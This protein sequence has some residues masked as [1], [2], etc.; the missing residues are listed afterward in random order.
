MVWC[1]VVWCGVVWCGVVCITDSVCVWSLTHARVVCILSDVCF[2]F[3]F[4]CRD[5][6]ETQM[7]SNIC[8]EALY[9]SKVRF[10]QI[11]L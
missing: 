8:R 7:E 3:V 2:L 11:G 10:C 9:V 6:F 4:D 5:D 1:G